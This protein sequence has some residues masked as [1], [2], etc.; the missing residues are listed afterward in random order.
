MPSSSTGQFVVSLAKTVHWNG[1]EIPRRMMNGLEF[2]DTGSMPSLAPD[3][4]VD[5]YLDRFWLVIP[6]QPSARQRLFWAFFQIIAAD[7]ERLIDKDRNIE[8]IDGLLG[9]V[10]NRLKLAPRDVVLDFGCG[11]GLSA[12]AP[13]AG[14]LRIV[15]YD[16]SSNMRRIARHRGL[17]VWS[18]R[19]LMGTPTGAIRAAIAS[20]VLHL[21]PPAAT[22]G[23]LWR[24]L[25][26]GGVVAANFHKGRGAETVTA[27]VARH[28]GHIESISSHPHHGPTFAFTKIR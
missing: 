17:E 15:G 25:G 16:A 24:K 1:R 13:R 27:I 10:V 9:A 18:P 20:Y 26:P 3:Q 6:S 12:L 19:D 8:N 21:V 28:G 14:T 5:R 4:H 22:F 7:Y 11:T 2:A 23:E